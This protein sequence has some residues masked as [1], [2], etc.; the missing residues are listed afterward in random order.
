MSLWRVD[1][2]VFVAV[3]GRRDS[4]REAGARG[5]EVAAAQAGGGAQDRT[6]QARAGAAGGAHTSVLPFV[7]TIDAIL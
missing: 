6:R 4:A 2:F 3:A 1:L 7:E 5:A